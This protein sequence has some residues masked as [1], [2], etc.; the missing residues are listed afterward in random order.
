MRLPLRGGRTS[1]GDRD[2]RRRAGPREASFVQNRM[3]GPFLRR[4]GEGASVKGPALGLI[5]SNSI[6]RGIV[7]TDQMVKRAPVELV[8]RRTVSPGKHL[9]LVTGEVADVEEAMRVGVETAAH[10]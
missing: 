10:T 5:E 3:N 4:E 2:R 6:A 9:T 7:V 1:P 8:L